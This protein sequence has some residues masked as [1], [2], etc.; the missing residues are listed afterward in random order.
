MTTQPEGKL[1]DALRASLKETQR[2][3]EQ[4][5]QLSSAAHEPIAIVGMACRFPGG[6][7]SPEDLWNLVDTGREGLGPFPADRGWDLE[8]LYDPTGERPGSSYVREGGF[9]YDAP[10]FDA[11]LFGIS[12]REALLMDPQ[13][14]LLLETGWEAMERAGIAPASLKGSRTGVFTGVMYH[15][16]P[17]HY[18]S[19]GVISGRVS[20]TFGLEGPAVTV[21]TACSSSLVTLHLAAQSLRQGECSLALVGGVSVMATPRTFVEF[22]IDGTLSSDGRCRA[23]AAAADGT[24]WSEGVGMLAVEKLSDARRNGHPVLAVIRG[25]AVNQDGA[26]NGITAPNGPSQQRVIRQALA[27]AGL[28]ARDVQAV[29]AHGTATALGD[30]IEAQA[31][32]ATYGQDRPADD[33]LWLGSVKSNIGHTQAA[34]GIAGLIKTVMSLRAGRLARTLH[35]DEPSR[36]VDWSAGEVR[37]LTEGRDWPATDGAPRRAA[38]SSFG[39]SGTNAHVIVEQAPEAAPGETAEEVRPPVAAWPLSARTAEALRGQA[40]RLLAWAQ[41]MPDAE[42]AAIG[43]ALV[44]GRSVLDHR[45]V[46]TGRDRTELLAGLTALAEGGRTASVAKGTSRGEAKTAFLFTGQGAQRVGMGR[47]LYESFPVFAAA[48]DAVCAAFDKELD[49]PLKDVMWEQGEAGLLDRTEYTQCALFAVEVALFRLLESWGVVPDFVAGHSIGELAAAHVAGVFELP[50]ACVLVAARGRLMGAL[51]EGGAMVAVS[52]PEAVVRDLLTPG[53]SL[54]AVN[55]PSSVVVSGEEAAVVA[56]AEA[57]AVQGF[58]TKRLRVSHAF[59]SALMEPMLQEFGRIAGGLSYAEPLIPVVSTLSGAVAGD[60]ELCAPEYWVRQVREAVRFGDAVAALEAAGVTVHAELG[61]DG[62][63]CGLAA[64]SLAAPGRATL[65]PALRK[66]RPETASVAGLAARLHANGTWLDWH[67]FHGAAAT[68][69]GG[70]RVDLPTYAF[71]KQR[72]WLNEQATGD[73]AAA[74]LVAAD[75]P[76]LGAALSAPATGGLVLTGRL[77][78]DSHGWLTDHT[79][80]GETVVPGTALVEMAIRAG[81]EAGTGRLDELTLEAPLVLPARGGVV[82]QVTV[83]APDEA[84]RRPV[85]V[86]ATPATEGVSDAVWTR[87]ATGRLA[88]AGPRPGFDLAQWPPPGAAAVSLDGFYARLAEG[89]LTYGPAFQGLRAVWQQGEVLYAECELPEQARADADRF[90]LHPALLDSALHAVGLR[91]GAQDGAGTAVPFAWNGVE[92]HATGATALRLRIS[93]G[94]GG[95]GQRVALDIADATGAPVASVTALDLRE[96]SADQLATAGRTGGLRDTLFRPVAEPFELTAPTAPSTV[97]DFEAALAGT[98]EVPEAAWLRAGGGNDA[99]AVRRATHHVLDVLQ[100]W[101]ADERLR[102]VPLAVVTSGAVTAG[103]TPDDTGVRDL[104]GAAVW[105]LVRS[106]QAEHPGRIRLVDVDGTVTDDEVRTL[107]PAVF[108]TEESQ[109][110]VRGT[111]AYTLRLARLAAERRASP[112]P[113]LAEG[114]VLITGASGALGT[115]L[116]RH[117]VTEHGARHLLLASRRGAR[118]DG[119]QALHDELTALGAGVTLAACDT[120]DRDALAALLSAVPAAHPLTAVL[121]TAGVLDDGVLS[122]LTPA[123]LDAV[124]YPKVDAALHLDELTRDAD[125]SAFVLFSSAAGVLG[126]PGQANYAAANAFLD[127]LAVRRSAEGL[128]AVSLAWGQWDQAQGMGG[129]GAAAERP[130]RKG[131]VLPLSADEGLALFDATWTGSVPH[132]VP[133]RLDPTALAAQG[134]ALPD[135]LRGLLPGRRRATAGTAGTG[136]DALR[137]QLTALPEDERH[138]VL[139]DLVRA[140]AAAVLGHGSGEAIEADRSF[141]DLG[142]DSLT[143][144]ELRNGLGAAT[145]VELPA[146]LVFDH[147]TPDTLSKYLYEKVL[148][149]LRAAAPRTPV[150]G[151]TDPADDP[152]VIVGMSCRYPGGVTSPEELWRLVADGVDGITPFPANRGWQSVG[153]IDRASGEECTPEGGFLDSAPE[154]DAGF[155]GLSPNEAVLI[156]PQQ[157]LLLEASWEALERSGIDP[158]SLKGSQTGVFA[159][160]FQND[161]GVGVFNAPDTGEDDPAREHA[162]IGIAQGSVVSGRVS[163]ALGLEGPAVTVDT[164][165]SS[166]L[167]ALH[168]AAQALRQGE[169]DLALAGGVTVMAT[170]EPFVEFSRQGGLARDGRAKAYGDGADGTTWSEGVGVLVVER[171]S[172]ARRNGHRVLALLRSSAVNQDGASNGLTAP[173][174]PSQQRLIQRALSVAGLAPA[175]IDAVEGHGTGTTLG[176]PIEAQALLATYGQDRPQDQPLWLGSVKSN[177]GHAQAAAGVA[178][179]IKMV[180]AM[181]HG[182]LPKTLYADQPSRH[183][184]WTSGQVRLLTETRDWPVGDRPRRA[185]VSAFGLSGTNAHAVLEEPGADLLPAVDDEPA[186]VTSR[187]TAAL[188]WLVTARTKGGLRTQAARLLSYATE[189]P[190]RSA[191]DIGHS[192][193]TFRAPFEH[194]A[195]VLG[196]DREALTEGLRALAEG[197]ADAPSV[198]RGAARTSGRTAF[199]FTGQGAQRPGMGRELYASFGVFADVFDAVCTQFDTH[200]DQPLKEIVFA[201]PGTPA[202]SLLG[203][204]VYTQAALFALETAQFRLLQSWGVKPDLLIGH[205]IGEIVAAHVSGVFTL[206]DAVTLVA[207][208]GQ[209]M[210]ELSSGG[211]MIAV[212][213]SEAEVAPL[214][215]GRETQVGIAAVNGPQAVVISG[216]EDAVVDIATRLAGT[217]RRTRRLAVRR[218]F[219]SPHMEPMLD[220]LREVA[221]T[222]TY[223]APRTPLLS[224][225]TGRTATAEELASPD[226]WVRHVRE[227]VRF[228]DGLLGAQSAGATRFVE[229]GPDGVL[230]A[231]ARTALGDATAPMALEP[232]SRRDRPEAQTLLGALAALHAHGMAVDWAKVYAGRGGRGVQLPPYAFDRKNYWLESAPSTALDVGRAGLDSGGGHPLLGASVDLAE[233]DGAVSTGRL[234]LSDQPW[235]AGHRVGG[236]V[237]F[238]GAGFVELAV[239]AGDRFGYGLVRELTM[240]SPLVVPETGALRVQVAVG[241]PEHGGLRPVSVHARPEDAPGAGWTRHARG[242]LAPGTGTGTV[243]TEQTEQTDWPPAGAQSVELTGFYAALADAGLEYGPEFRGVR[244]AWRAGDEVYAEIVLDDAVRGDAHRFGVHPALLDAALHTIG[245]RESEG[246]SGLPFVWSDV[247]LHAAGA[248]SVRV[249]LRPGPEGVAFE[250]SDP[251][252]QSVLSV[253][254]LALREIPAAQLDAARTAAAAPHDALFTLN[255]APVAPGGEPPQGDWA[256]LGSDAG[257]LRDAVATA[258][259]TVTGYRDLDALLAAQGPLPATVVLDAVTPQDLLPGDAAAVAAATRRTLAT[260]QRWLA[261]ERCARSTLTVLTRRAVVVGDEDVAD[262]VGAG[263]CGLVRGAQSENPGRFLLADVDGA[264]ASLAALPQALAAVGEPQLVVREGVVHGVR[265][266]RPQAVTG[267]P[268]STFGPS[269]TVL[270]TGATGT[271]GALVARHLVEAEGVRRLLLLSRSGEAA[272]GARELVEELT[273]LGAEVRLTACDAGDRAALAAVLAAVPQE[274]PLTGVVHAAGV[275]DDGVLPSL[276]PEQLD[277][278]LRPKVDAALNLHELTGDAGLTAFVLFSSAAGPLGSPGQ[279]NYA[280][281]NAFLDALAAHRRAQGLAGQSLAFGLWA[282]PTGMTREMS[283]SYR[284]RISRAGMETLTTAEGLALFSAASRRSEPLLLPSRIGVTDAAGAP[285]DEVPHFLRELVA[286]ARRGAVAERRGEDPGTLRKR[287]AG[288]TPREREQALLVL[289]VEQAA[290]L[291]GHEDPDALSPER[292]FLDSGFDSLTAMELRT[293]LN[294]ETGL[295]LESTAV[296]DHSTPELLARHLAQGLENQE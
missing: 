194:R 289:V 223:G 296:F 177:I 293:R 18:G 10:E 93:P 56:L 176:D 224:N 243:A 209:L 73:V 87:H 221:E 279:A 59:H 277:T 104:A 149:T 71:Q 62:V 65:A 26:S 282:Q 270:V 242:V 285:G 72:Y 117:L 85:S 30:P 15:N 280:A 180:L 76:L 60:G 197:D 115:L 161:Y 57:C 83:D 154:F 273:A 53:V 269:G 191:L 193:A 295:W 210:Q 81:D 2:L 52:A 106:A 250:L 169:C 215:E 292:E 40:E 232:L 70:Q 138:R 3:R 265:L 287:L 228:H 174:G 137:K 17:G 29:E 286:P 236:V 202:A 99:E 101:S 27:N 91:P 16:Y 8:R 124:L 290:R 22:S 251:T 199:L 47:E 226:Y 100:R 126:A 207:A 281:A 196:G 192:L 51:P 272:P 13:Q 182:K 68:A 144:V 171:L 122:S 6:V 113:A 125:L 266:G 4:N 208:R 186:E 200:L 212:A 120:A 96:I 152:V 234:S 38:V 39:M 79:V 41:D 102:A 97:L 203:Q 114:T 82:V 128:P 249:A 216:D 89:D 139:E 35:I 32:L 42:P 160:A 24:G 167:V 127:A 189:H 218:A 5:R 291:L 46:V 94:T 284:A 222:L 136:E 253:R 37:L 237:L 235:L 157:R 88:P 119:A 23:F 48:L 230:T 214:I 147:P 172:D 213:A 184:D 247:E 283:D 268:S 133:V 181:Q 198:V 7:R 229:I 245:L 155:F 261:D 21:D 64:D 134:D 258:E 123:R 183:V 164:A 165:C 31:L 95:A 178:G 238:P 131:G 12:P 219:H 84:G 187:D 173:N 28:A 255:W 33:P 256:V 233:S 80:F 274:H 276:T 45:A 74:G 61:P 294:T 143:A 44:D 75:H 50:D 111:H 205:S 231:M 1:V 130:R 145:G 105:G 63:L 170:P 259:R 271:L 150:R 103:N 248:S 109:L 19:S 168:W 49:R 188:P 67:A 55:G 211:A 9:L 260:L 98:G 162:S 163:Y 141:Q 116:A 107:L 240:E 36:Q 25:S 78:R 204:T 239:R 275:L 148:G 185:A 90:G 129:G 151:A 34:A 92:L 175:D 156:D 135:V 263:V 264:D 267:G 254:N 140:Q 179:V 54:A 262:L 166:S 69:P 77:T 14:R 252:G 217:G 201:E 112:A 20:Y 108:A 146:T 257:A 288:L 66:D 190:E 86:Y 246:G 58:K 244:A 110:A 195:L 278:V 227:A 153:L 43:R 159:G 225:V 132:A 142:F 206:A 121:H 118:A 220:E 241:A 11:D 158:V